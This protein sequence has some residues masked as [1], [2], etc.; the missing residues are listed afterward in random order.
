MKSVIADNNKKGFGFKIVLF[1][2]YGSSFKN[3]I[4]STPIAFEKESILFIDCMNYSDQELNEFAE[5]NLDEKLLSSL[6]SA[7]LFDKFCQN[8]INCSSCWVMLRSS[9]TNQ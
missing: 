3:S 2:A 4:S 1:A 7:N 9:E 8:L 5:K 6:T